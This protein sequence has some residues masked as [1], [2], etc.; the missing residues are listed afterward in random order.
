MEIVTECQICGYE[1]DLEEH[2]KFRCPSTSCAKVACFSC[3]KRYI[4]DSENDANCMFCF[5]VISLDYF[6]KRVPLKFIGELRHHRANKVML[7]ME[8]NLLS[9]TMPYVKF[10]IAEIDYNHKIAKLTEEL[11]HIF[12]QPKLTDYQRELQTTRTNL[13]KRVYHQDLMIL[14]EDYF[15]KSGP[16]FVYSCS[17][18]TGC[19]GFVDINGL[20]GVCK[21]QTCIKCRIT[22]IDNKHECKREDLASAELITNDTKGCPKC[23]TRIYKVSGCDH[24]FCI[25]CKTGFDWRTLKVLD[26]RRNTNPLYDEWRR[27]SNDST[28]DNLLMNK[29]IFFDRNE[30][31]TSNNY[32][33]KIFNCISLILQ[34]INDRSNRND[35]QRDQN[36]RLELRI[37]YLMKEIDEKQ[38][39]SRL[40]ALHKREEKKNETHQVLT[41][42]A[43]NAID[44]I[45]CLKDKRIKCPEIF[46][47]LNNLRCL[48]NEKMASL[49]DYF[50]GN[51]MHHIAD[52]WV[53]ST[54]KQL[55]K[56]ERVVI[57]LLDES[58]DVPVVN[59]KPRSTIDSDSEDEIP[60]RRLYNLDKCK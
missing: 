31:H 11:E 2:R 33:L 58:D 46:F 28:Q 24:M 15:G 54:E 37:K 22:N 36:V 12:S 44:H 51:M 16:T 42:F 18:T 32:F 14:K 59:K 45:N 49:Q 52:D 4:I 3:V 56:R 57:S 41:T 23:G 8:K 20:C 60:L 38:W 50:D 21:K 7:A 53:F 17:S 10:K 43:R 48:F 39:V 6:H 1:I 47:K 19:R 55:K 40:K 9:Q 5:S 13:L 29:N 30:G 35:W 34:K 27:Q 25:H 26:N